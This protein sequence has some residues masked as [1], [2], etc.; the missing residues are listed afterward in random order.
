M[1]APL[2][3][4]HSGTPAQMSAVLRDADPRP[5]GAHR[6][7]CVCARVCL[8][9]DSHARGHVRPHV[10]MCLC[11][12]AC[13]CTCLC[14]Y[15]FLCMCVYMHTC[16]QVQLTYPFGT[17]QRLCSVGPRQIGGNRHS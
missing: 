14:V 8:H 7:W 10:C 11:A 13:V 6:L 16:F 2:L 5:W 3:L 15:V 1:A 4:L 9:T 17:R 12:C